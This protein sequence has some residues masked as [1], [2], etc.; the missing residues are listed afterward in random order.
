MAILRVRGHFCGDGE[1]G[2]RQS[3]GGTAKIFSV[4][5]TIFQIIWGILHTCH[6]PAKK[7]KKNVKYIQGLRIF[8]WLHFSC[9]DAQSVK[10]LKHTNIQKN[11]FDL[12]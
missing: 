7:I 12:A 10:T 6:L 2:T 9:T 5:G 1:L 3:L 8:V 4:T 11:L